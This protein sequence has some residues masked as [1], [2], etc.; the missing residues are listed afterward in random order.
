MMERLLAK[1]EARM[2]ANA[3]ANQE[4]LLAK[5]D[6]NPK[7]AEADMDELKAKMAAIRSELE[8]TMERR[9]KNLMMATWNTYTE[10]KKIEQGIEM[11]QS[12]EEHQD[13]PSEDIE[14]LR[15]RHRGQ[16]LT[17]G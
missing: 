11:M 3:K 15:K 17:A 16:K 4:E 12:T 1:L 2:N 5:M 10:V 6:S 8:E 9:M 13:V 7:K 14:G